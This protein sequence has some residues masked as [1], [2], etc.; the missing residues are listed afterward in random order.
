MQRNFFNN[1]ESGVD[2]G[3]VCPGPEPSNDLLYVILHL[4]GKKPN[5][6]RTYPVIHCFSSLPPPGDG[7]LKLSWTNPA[8]TAPGDYDQLRVVI[9]DQSA[10]EMLYVRLPAN[11]NEITIPADWVKILQDS[12][13]L[14]TVIWQVQTRS[15]TGE[16][17]N[18]ARGNS[19]WIIIPGFRA[20]SAP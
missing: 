2:Q 12:Y 18:Y 5:I 20:P 4:T 17:M 7:S 16:D 14:T 11:V 19:D 15:Y 9:K 13:T 6:I 1:Q 3:C 10:G 8:N